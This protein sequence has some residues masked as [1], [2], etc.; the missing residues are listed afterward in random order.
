LRF[1]FG[2]QALKLLVV[3]TSDVN[4]RK[5]RGQGMQNVFF[6]SRWDNF[7]YF[8]LFSMEIQ[9]SFFHRKYPKKMFKNPGSGKKPMVANAP[10]KLIPLIPLQQ[11]ICI[12]LRS[13]DVKSVLEE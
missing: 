9:R 10:S 4:S 5:Y 8:S 1:I 2:K 6:I 7:V 12:S 3:I 13:N 11:Y